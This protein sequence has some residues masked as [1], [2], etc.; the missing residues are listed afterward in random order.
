MYIA[1][2]DDVNSSSSSFNARSIKTLCCHG[3]LFQ[4]NCFRAQSGIFCVRAARWWPPQLLNFVSLRLNYRT[5][6]IIQ[7]FHDVTGSGGDVGGYMTEECGINWRLAYNPRWVDESSESALLLK[8]KVARDLC[9]NILKDVLKLQF[10]WCCVF[11]G[12]VNLYCLR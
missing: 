1:L 3:K 8:V 12:A 4:L 9:W 10:T 7:R 6:W 2:P 5:Q 11:I